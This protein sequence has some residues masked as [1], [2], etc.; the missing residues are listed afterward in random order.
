MVVAD[1]R[2]R[3]EMTPSH[4]SWTYQVLY[5]FTDGQDGAYPSSLLIFDSAGNLYGTTTSA[6]CRMPGL[7]LR[8][9]LQVDLFGF[10][11]A[12]HTLYSFL[13]GT[14]G[15]APSAG[16][17]MDSAGNLYGATPAATL[18]AERCSNLL[19]RVETGRS[20]WLTTLAATDLDLPK[21]C[22]G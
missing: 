2:G 19:P 20:I 8:H 15:S 5:T 6:D 17:L 12:E 3:L 4:G 11:L 22:S 18:L 13:D 1:P 16:V 14:D 7:W 21:S 10:R 9:G